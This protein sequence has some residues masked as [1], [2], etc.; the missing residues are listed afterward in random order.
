[1]R[2][3][4]SC[5]AHMHPLAKSTLIDTRITL[6]KHHVSISQK[7]LRLGAGGDGGVPKDALLPL[8]L[9]QI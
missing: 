1:M 3:G 5:T 4:L 8:L 7:S 6:H 2:T 9:F